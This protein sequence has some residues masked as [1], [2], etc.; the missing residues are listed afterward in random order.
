MLHRLIPL[1]LAVVV[2][3]TPIVGEIC[4]LSCAEAEA[5]SSSQSHHGAGSSS[6]AHH[7]MPEHERG[8]PEASGGQPIAAHDHDGDESAPEHPRGTAGACGLSLSAV[9]H[10]CGHQGKWQAAS[11]PAAKIMIAAPVVVPEFAAAADLVA[12]EAPFA[13]IGS[14][15]PV[16]IPLALRTPLRV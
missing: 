2:G 7:Q 4:Q 10:R 5:S 8:R 16:P 12:N 6:S 3:V 14:L 13:S 1:V 11:A 15:A 9:P